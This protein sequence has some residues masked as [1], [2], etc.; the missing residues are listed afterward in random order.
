MEKEMFTSEKYMTKG[1]DSDLA[2]NLQILIWGLIENMEIEKDY[3]QVFKMRSIDENSV[4]IIHKQEIPTYEK[5]H[6]ISELKETADMNI[7]VIDSGE[8]CTMM[9]AHEY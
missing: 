9:L 1:I 4:K 7:F 2:Q 5:E 6:I 8:Y 3:L